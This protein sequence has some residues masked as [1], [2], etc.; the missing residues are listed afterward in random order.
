ML[1]DVSR[2]RDCLPAM[3]RLIA[4]MDESSELSLS[5]VHVVIDG[6]LA[7]TPGLLDHHP[8]ISCPIASTHGSLREDVNIGCHV[9]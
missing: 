8:R 6:S 7:H 1:R 2:L 9:M 3:R 4:D 5:V